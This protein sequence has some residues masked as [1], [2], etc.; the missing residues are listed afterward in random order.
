MYV[1]IARVW[2]QD[3][4]RR[5]RRREEDRRGEKRRR[6]TRLCRTEQLRAR[7]TRTIRVG[8][9]ASRKSRLWK[10]ARA[11]LVVRPTQIPLLVYIECR[12]LSVFL[13]FLFFLYILSSTSLLRLSRPLSDVRVVLSD[14]TTTER[15][16]RSPANV[17]EK[18]ALVP[19]RVTRAPCTPLLLVAFA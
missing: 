9:T 11:G 7:D 3:A 12:S 8:V 18:C 5:S 14:L 16:S 2:P 15:L 19:A 1:Y 10:Q 4:E 17:G 13:Y 6:R